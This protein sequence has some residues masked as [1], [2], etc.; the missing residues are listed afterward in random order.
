MSSHLQT[1]SVQDV[2]SEQELILARVGIFEFEEELLATTTICPKHRYQL[3]GGWFKRHTCR[4][5]GHK[6]NAKPSRTINKSQSRTIVEKIGTLVPVGS[7][8]KPRE[9]NKSAKSSI[10]K[11][12]FS[13]PPPARARSLTLYFDGENPG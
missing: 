11:K 8:K 3:G 12:Y 4:F 9:P 1:I 10:M 13:L 5:P 2:S 7:G 6:G